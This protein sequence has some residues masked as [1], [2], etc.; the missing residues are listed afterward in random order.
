MLAAFVERFAARISPFSSNAL[1]AVKKLLNRH[2]RA[3]AA[4]LALSEKRI[5]KLVAGFG[6]VGRLRRAVAPRPTA[7]ERI[8]TSRSTLY[9][10]EPQNT[11][12]TVR[13]LEIQ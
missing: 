2:A 13:V 4:E 9:N 10:G 12:A 5:Y 3:A 11:G 1:R 6:G 8:P 7:A